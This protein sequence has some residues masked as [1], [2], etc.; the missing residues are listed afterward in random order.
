MDNKFKLL[1]D[2]ASYLEVKH[3]DKHDTKAKLN[4]INYY[5]RV[6]HNR[7]KKINQMKLKRGAISKSYSL[8]LHDI[9]MG[10]NRDVDF[11]KSHPLEIIYLDQLIDIG[12]N[13]RDITSF[14]NCQYDYN[15]KNINR[16]SPGLITNE[17]LDNLEIFNTHPRENGFKKRINI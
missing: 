14:D 3:T 2:A 5:K 9:I 1:L 10:F 8:I 15:P 12:V 11:L 13:I 4:K 17:K 6:N 16:N 7:I